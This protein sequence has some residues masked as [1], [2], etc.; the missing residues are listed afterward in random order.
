MD[1][2]YIEED[3]GR[4]C[5]TLDGCLDNA[6]KTYIARVNRFRKDIDKSGLREICKRNN[7]TVQE[8]LRKGTK[9]KLTQEFFF[10]E[11]IRMV[12]ILCLDDGLLESSLE[13]KDW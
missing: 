12:L 2:F 9:L 10:L 7:T 11:G 8:E 5:R 1:G 4:I 6:Y 13:R 3:T